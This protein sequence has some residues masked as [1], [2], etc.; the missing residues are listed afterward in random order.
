MVPGGE[1]SRANIQK[2]IKPK[3]L[4]SISGS[5]IRLNVSLKNLDTSYPTRS[6]WLVKGVFAPF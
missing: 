5:T 1:E 2:K 3:T 4:F 6:V